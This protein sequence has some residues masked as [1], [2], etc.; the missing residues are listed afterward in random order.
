MTHLRA[1]R[2]DG[3]VAPTCTSSRAKAPGGRGPRFKSASRLNRLCAV[4]DAQPR[5]GAWTK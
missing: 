2:L 3:T 4:T 5:K 1:R